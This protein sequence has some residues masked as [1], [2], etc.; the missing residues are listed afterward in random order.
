[1]SN[2]CYRNF[3]NFCTAVTEYFNPS[4]MGTENARKCH[5]GSLPREGPVQFALCASCCHSTVFIIVKGPMVDQARKTLIKA[6]PILVIGVVAVLGYVFLRDYLSF[7]ALADNRHALEMYRDDHYMMTVLIFMTVYALIV[8]FSLPGAT[9]ATLTGGFLFATFPGSLINVLAATIGA[10]MIFMA[11]KTGLGDRLA[12][13][14][15]AGSGR[16]HTIKE[17]IDRDQWSIL[18]IMRL[19]PVIPFFVANVLPALVGVPLLRFVVSTFLG[20]IPG[21]LVYTSVGAG[22]GSVFD[23]GETPDLGIIFEPQILLPLL[24]LAALSLLPVIIRK[25]RKG[26]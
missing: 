24:G 11:A 20:I 23:R 9:I 22:L 16:W 6:L 18:F 1:M 17:E 5:L 12:A 25:F 3:G 26:I 8:A 4:E 14:M 19:V 2:R 21:A 10:T 7:Q 13:R 15:D